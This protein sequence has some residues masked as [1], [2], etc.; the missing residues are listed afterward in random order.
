MIDNRIQ[1]IEEFQKLIVKTIATNRIGVNLPLI[2]GFRFRLLDNSPRFSIDIDYHCH[3]DLHQKQGELLRVFQ[4]TV[5]PLTKQ[6]TGYSGSASEKIGPDADS[7]HNKV[8]DIAFFKEGTPYSRM[9]T[10]IDITRIQRMDDP[11]AKTFEGAII[12]T[13]SDA[14]MIESKVLSLFNRIYLQERDMVDLYLFKDKFREDS[15]ERISE[16]I[17]RS[18]LDWDFVKK[19]FKK[20]IGDRDYHIR[21][22]NTIIEEQFDAIATENLRIGGGGALV[23]DQAAGILKILLKLPGKRKS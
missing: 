20:I 6:K 19:R 22:I 23:F 12:L 16:K 15:P 10:C 2:G 5:L 7:P 18:T 21:N 3:G 9:E 11:V 8:L 13:L 14:D 4:S 17:T 1:K